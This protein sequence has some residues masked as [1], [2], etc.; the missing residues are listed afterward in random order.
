MREKSKLTPKQMHL[1]GLLAEG[2]SQREAAEVACLSRSTVQRLLKRESFKAEV[3]RRKKLARLS[4]DAIAQAL[5]QDV[6]TDW[7]NSIQSHIQ[8]V[9][10]AA[11]LSQAGGFSAVTKALRRLKD[12]PDESLKPADAIALVKAGQDLLAA[13]FEWKA[14]TLGL[15][16]LV[17]RLEGDD[18]PTSY[19]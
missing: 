9:E 3:E 19:H 18:E 15:H 1:A 11:V 17:Q 2:I 13:S 8:A 4:P 12:L 7:L 10:R 16:E 14:E 6:S 5:E